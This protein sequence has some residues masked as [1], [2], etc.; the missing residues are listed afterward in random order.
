[1]KMA[2]DLLNQFKSNENAWLCVDQIL[3]LSQNQNSK[4]LA[5]QILDEAVNVSIY[6]VNLI[7]NFAIDTME[8]PTSKLKRR[9]Q[10][11]HNSA[12]HENFGGGTRSEWV[13]VPDQ[14]QFHSG[15]HRQIGVDGQLEQLH[16]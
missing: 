13:S 4:F 1:M 3:E 5:L 14:T 10:K 16:F 6:L 7:S 15:Q 8:N 12:C 11:L 9:H 2:N